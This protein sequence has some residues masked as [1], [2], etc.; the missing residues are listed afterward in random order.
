MNY[1]TNTI[2]GLQARANPSTPEGAMYQRLTAFL[3][4]AFYSISNQLINNNRNPEARHF[5]ELYKMDDPTN[6]EAWYFSAVLNARDNN[7]KGAEADLI[8]AVANG[9][10]DQGRMM[11]QNEFKV[12]SIDLNAIAAKM[13]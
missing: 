7:A 3:S 11:Q 10:A 6:S 13:K 4:L 1:W 2:H 12:L 5:V 8:E 9:F